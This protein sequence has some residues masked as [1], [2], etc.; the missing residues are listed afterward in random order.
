MRDCNE[1]EKCD[2]CCPIE[3][4]LTAAAPFSILNA[5]QYEIELKIFNVVEKSTLRRQYAH[6]KRFSSRK[7]QINEQF[8]FQKPHTYGMVI[9]PNQNGEVI[10]QLSGDYYFI[11]Y[12]DSET[13]HVIS[14]HSS[15][16]A[17]Y[18]FNEIPMSINDAKDRKSLLSAETL[19]NEIV[20]F[21]SVHRQSLFPT[22]LTLLSCY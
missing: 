1:I 5:L 14:L 22:K 4:I 17:P 7:F 9:V 19:R 10:E 12:F 20:S 15:S 2:E 16:M 8:L 13:R 21:A 6:L 3:P 18:S 11:E